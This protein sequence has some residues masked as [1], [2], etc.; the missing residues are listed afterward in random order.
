MGRIVREVE[1][2]GAVGVYLIDFVEHLPGLANMMADA[3]S[4][5]KVPRELRGARRDVLP[6]LSENFWRTR[7]PLVARKSYLQAF[8]EWYF[9]QDFEAGARVTPCVVPGGFPPPP[10]VRARWFPSVA[11]LGWLS[12]GLVWLSEGRDPVNLSVLLGRTLLPTSRR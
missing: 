2:G 12:V 1:A 6:K 7:K 5:L 4:H 9:D 10:V 11:C 8:S 3:L